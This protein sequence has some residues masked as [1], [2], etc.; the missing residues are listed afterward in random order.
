MKGT[1]SGFFLLGIWGGRVLPGAE[2]FLFPTK[3]L[4]FNHPTKQQRARNQPIKG[5]FSC[6]HCNHCNH[7][8]LHTLCTH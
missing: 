4:N 6:N 7:F 8:L 5:F 1:I 3:P 2:D